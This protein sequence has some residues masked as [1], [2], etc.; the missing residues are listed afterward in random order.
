[1]STRP[2]YRIGRTDWLGSP[3]WVVKR[4]GVLVWVATPFPYPLAWEACVRH[5]IACQQ[6]EAA[7]R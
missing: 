3:R 7:G 5:V 1:M 6:Q 2:R 4:N